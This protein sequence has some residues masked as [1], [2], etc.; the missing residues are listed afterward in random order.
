[1]EGRAVPVPVP[2]PAGEAQ[3]RARPGD[4][5]SLPACQPTEKDRPRVLSATRTIINDA[6]L[7][8]A[9]MERERRAV[10][11]MYVLGMDEVR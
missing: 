7:D 6:R 4:R 5:N 3:A 1:M 9:W 8:H 10:V 2:V 11:T